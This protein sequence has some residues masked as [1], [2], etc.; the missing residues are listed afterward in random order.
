MENQEKQKLEEKEKTQKE[1]KPLF[2]QEPQNKRM[3]P[4]HRVIH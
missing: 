4:T 2:S 1:K 3:R